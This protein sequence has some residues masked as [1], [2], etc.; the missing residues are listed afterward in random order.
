MAEIKQDTK[1]VYQVTAAAGFGRWIPDD[2][3]VD[4]LTTRVRFDDWEPPHLTFADT[5][6]PLPTYSFIDGVSSA[7]VVALVDDDLGTSSFA[8]RAGTVVDL[9]G[10][11]LGY[12]LVIPTVERL[13]DTDDSTGL[14]KP[15][16][17]KFSF[18]H[19]IPDYLFRS[20]PRPDDLYCGEIIYPGEAPVTDLKDWSNMA[21]R[22][23]YQ[24]N[25]S[26]GLTFKEIWRS[27]A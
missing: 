18:R 1:I 17:D 4:N 20:I 21:F 22:V 8:E 14:H 15:Q 27:G 19:S 12:S 24:L 9:A 5:A 26:N 3:L 11:A 23:W 7:V 2:A 6:G 13:V 10:D 16:P 25:E